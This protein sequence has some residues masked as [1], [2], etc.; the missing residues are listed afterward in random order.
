MLKTVSYHLIVVWKMKKVYAF[1]AALLTIPV[2]TWSEG[3][4]SPSSDSDSYVYYGYAPACNVTRL[5][6]VGFNDTTH[7]EIYDLTAQTLLAS[8]TVNRMGLYTYEVTESLGSSEDLYFKVVADKPVAA[9]LSGVQKLIFGE[10]YAIS[11]WRGFDTFYPS[12]DGGFSGKEFIFMATHTIWTPGIYMQEV[13]VHFIFGVEDSHVTVFDSDGVKVAEL[14][15]AAGSFNKISLE[16][17]VVYKIASTGRI[18]T[19]GLCSEA[20]T[21]VPSLT[22]GFVGRSFYCTVAADEAGQGETTSLVVLAHEDAD[23]N[24]Y[25]SGRPGWHIQLF[26]SDVKK[27]LKR[28]ELWYNDT[29]LASMP[30]RIESA[31]GISVLVG[32]GG[33]WWGASSNI[34]AHMPQNIGDDISFIGVGAGEKLRFYAPTKAVLFATRD[35]SVNLDGVLVNIKENEP[36]TVLGG[37]HVLQADAPIIVE[38][39]GEGGW[40]PEFQSTYLKPPTGYESWGSYLISAQFLEVTYPQPPPISAISELILFTA[41]GVAVSAVLIVLLVW[42]RRART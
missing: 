38:V 8:A 16:E 18:L 4:S 1:L 34:T 7:V 12:T 28:G 31:G 21:Y 9:C 26:G 20:F 24:V 11:A 41:A 15:A 32:N 29:I 30:L 23:V 35:S 13:N 3:L 19:V 42:K 27:T 39:L 37:I 17:S 22:G 5:D 6:I 10:R 36:L 33:N 14:D 2:L 40:D 25:D